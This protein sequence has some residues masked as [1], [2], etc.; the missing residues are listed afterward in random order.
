MLTDDANDTDWTRPPFRFPPD[1]PDSAGS[2]EFALLSPI[3][4]NG[5][6]AVVEV[7]SGAGRAPAEIAR[8]ILQSHGVTVLPSAVSRYMLH[9]T[10]VRKA[11]KLGTRPA[12]PELDAAITE[13]HEELSREAPL[14]LQR[15]DRAIAMLEDVVNAKPEMVAGV[16]TD[17]VL[18]ERVKAAKEL[19]KA[20]AGKYEVTKRKLLPDET[21]NS[22]ETIVDI[23]RAAYG[24]A[25]QIQPRAMSEDPLGLL[26][27]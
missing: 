6:G 25:V 5:L 9:V 23:L 3:L 21:A 12:H 10:V 22:Q 20:V 4:E 16:T 24:P 1:L 7:M 8:E 17:I 26:G 15:M 14:D 11:R 19:I 13:R 2:S 18:R 27:K